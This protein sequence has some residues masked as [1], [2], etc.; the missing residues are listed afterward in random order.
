MPSNALQHRDVPTTRALAGPDAPALDHASGGNMKTLVRRSIDRGHANHG[1]LDTHH[2]FSFA[3]Y[4]DPRFM[5]FG[6]L[7]VINQD[8]VDAGRGFAQHA[9][10][11]MEIISYVVDGALEH[12]DTLGTGSVIKPGDVQLMSAG[13]GIAHSEYNH[14][15][16]EGVQFLQI[17]VLPAQRGTAPRY[18]QKA[19][20]LTERGLQ[21]VVSPDGRDGSLTIGQDLDLYRLLLDDGAT[22]HLKPRRGNVWVQVIRGPLE[23]AGEVL[24]PGDGMAVTEA[25]ALTFR[26]QAATEALIFDLS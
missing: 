12:T 1:W 19:F 11:D 9:H 2:T 5:G 14:S 26:A 25:E 15:R 10:R 24:Q 6:H 13:R 23:V 16:A 7:R 3:G 17:W 22:A 18:D 8:T 20:A 21:L 4:H